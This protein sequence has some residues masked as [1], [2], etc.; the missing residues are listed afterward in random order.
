MDDGLVTLEKIKKM[1]EGSPG[2]RTIE[3]AD[4]EFDAL[5]AEAKSE[6][7]VLEESDTAFSLKAG[8][9]II[10]IQ[11]DEEEEEEE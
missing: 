7:A 3:V 11:K 5:L 1:F 9:G 2:T 6:N 4:S 10:N 8:D